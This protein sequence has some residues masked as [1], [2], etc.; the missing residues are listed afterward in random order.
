VIG[1]SAV[2]FFASLVREAAK[3]QGI[4]VT[5]K[6]QLV[7]ETLGQEFVS[8]WPKAFGLAMKRI[9]TAGRRDAKMLRASLALL[10]GS[11]SAWVANRNY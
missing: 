1:S 7:K 4:A 11:I 2:L 5:R 3:L 10:I 9:V 6:L 8:S